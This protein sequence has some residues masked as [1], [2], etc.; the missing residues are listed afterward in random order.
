M[1]ELQE[2]KEEGSFKADQRD[3]EWKHYYTENGKLRFIGKFVDGVPDGMHIYYY[4]NG[5]ERQAGKYVGGLKESEWKFYDEAG[6][7]FLTILYKNDVEIRFD[8]I[9]VLPETST[10]EPSI[11]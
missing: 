6:F 10:S 7:L 9:K 8:G 4:L 5:K 2:Y 3:A 11:K 1:L